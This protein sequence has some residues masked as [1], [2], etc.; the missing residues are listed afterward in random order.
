[1]LWG[2]DPPGV[3]R[4]PGRWGDTGFSAAAQAW[5]LPAVTAGLAMPFLGGVCGGGNLKQSPSSMGHP[6]ALKQG[7]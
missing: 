3:T 1:M 2:C 7:P 6:K 5:F 4:H